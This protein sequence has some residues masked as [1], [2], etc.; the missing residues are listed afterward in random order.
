[1]T[2]EAKFHLN[3]GDFTLAVDLHLPGQGITAI[4]GPSGCG[5]TS[6]LRLLAGLETDPQGYLSVRGDLWQDGTT[7]VPTH[8]RPVGYVSQES[9]LFPHLT[10]RGNLEYGVRRLPPRGRQIALDEVVELFRLRTLL[11]RSPSGLSGGERKRVAIAQALL[12]SPRLLLMDEPLTALDAEAKAEIIS[13]LEQL[14]EKL[15]VPVLYVSHLLGEVAR[16][17]DHLVL[18]KEGRVRISGPFLETINRLDTPLAVPDAESIIEA[19]VASHDRSYHLTQLAFAGGT[20]TVPKA[21]LPVGHRVRLRVLARDVSLVLDRPSNTSILNILPA[22]VT[23]L[24]HDAL[25]LSLVK[26]D[27]GDGVGMFACITRKSC[28][29][30]KLKPGKALF[31]QIKTVALLEP[32]RQNSKR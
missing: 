25:A 13:S 23:G 32:F 7:F 15:Q 9:H 4:F 21:P 29:T 19:T 28:Q 14:L 24:R 18:M 17:A 30:L 8:Q 22:T 16:L 6:L 1:M 10:V 31:A 3:R 5:K 20:I 27:I 2:I 26:L 12:T 11:D